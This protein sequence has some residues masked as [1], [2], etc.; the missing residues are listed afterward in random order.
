MRSAAQYVT[1]Y[2]LITSAPGCLWMEAGGLYTTRAPSASLAPLT[3]QCARGGIKVAYA[4]KDNM[5]KISIANLI[6]GASH[7]PRQRHV[8]CS[9]LSQSSHPPHSTGVWCVIACQFWFSCLKG[10][11][12]KNSTWPE[13]VRKC[14]NSHIC[15]F[16]LMVVS[17][18]GSININAKQC[19]FL[20]IWAPRDAAMLAR[21]LQMKQQRNLLFFTTS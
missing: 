17:F 2:H 19:F 10:N 16:Y 12:G 18:S 14:A 20:G 1:I 3:L 6:I 8:S 7:I 13:N 15:V 9:F 5:T 4:V 11:R 21:S